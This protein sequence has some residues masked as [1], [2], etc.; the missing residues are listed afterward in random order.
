MKILNVMLSHLVIIRWAKFGIMFAIL[1]AWRLQ[2]TLARCNFGDRADLIVNSWF[3]DGPPPVAHQ[4]RQRNASHSLLSI[5]FLK[6]WSD[7]I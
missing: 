1:L 3:N 2:M 4:A 5:A 7:M 6:C